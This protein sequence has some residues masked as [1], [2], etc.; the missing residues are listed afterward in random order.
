MVMIRRVQCRYGGSSQRLAWDPVTAV[1]ASSTTDTDEMVSFC[2]PKFTLAMLRVSCLEEWSSEELTE[3][4]Q[5][6]IAWLI[7]GSQVD[8]CVGTLQIRAM[9]GGCFTSYRLVWDPGPFT[10]CRLVRDIFTWRDFVD[11]ML[12]YF[13]DNAWM[14]A[15]G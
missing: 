7:R 6:L 13:L 8:S 3:L 11:N 9:S 2:F 5:L 4:V 14:I 15:V 12:I 1:F 10:T